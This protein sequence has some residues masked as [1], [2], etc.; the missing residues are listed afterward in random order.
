MKTS[1]KKLL[2][3][4][5]ALMLGTQVY[6]VQKTTTFNVTARIPAICTFALSTQAD[7]AFGDY[8]PFATTDTSSNTDIKVRCTRG[9]AYTLSLNGGGTND[10]D[11]RKMLVSGG[12]RGT[13]G[14]ELGYQLYSSTAPLIVWGDG[15]KGS[16]VSATAANFS[17]IST[18]AYGVIPTNQ[19]AKE[20]DFSDTV[21]ITVEY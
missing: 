8:D 18:T 2:A 11:V 4:G 15:I 10:I 12:T 3:A 7:L 17:E 9:T 16:T 1:M 19:D 21:Q 20:G 14:D 5:A 6:A 13:E